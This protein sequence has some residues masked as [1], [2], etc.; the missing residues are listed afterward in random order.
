LLI[1]FGNSQERDDFMEKS[2]KIITSPSQLQEYPEQTLKDIEQKFE[3][4]LITPSKNLLTWLVNAGQTIWN[5]YQWKLIGQFVMLAF[6]PFFF[7]ADAIAISSVLDTLGLPVE[8]LPENILDLLGQYGIAVAAGTFFSVVISAFVIFEIFGSS[9][10]SEYGNYV[11]PL[12]TIV[13]VIAILIMVS[14]LVSGIAFGFQAW[15]AQGTL[16]TWLNP[17]GFVLFS[18]N[19]LVRANVLIATGVILLEAFKGLI[20]ILLIIIGI[21]LLITGII[22][23]ILS[24]VGSLGRIVIDWIIR[25]FRWV[26]WLISFLVFAPLDIIKSAPKDFITFMAGLF[27]KP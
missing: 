3:M 13:K 27:K 17:D 4:A 16:P 19:V 22:F 12:K 21:V 25:L 9:E 10:F 15:K 14:S 1:A 11:E 5:K 8:K 24:V 26:L 23:T 20:A 7:L 18:M 2:Y 6:L